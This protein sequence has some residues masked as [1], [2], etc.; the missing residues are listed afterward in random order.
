M[1]FEKEQREK[2]SIIV[3][4]YNVVQYLDDCVRSLI[5]QTYMNIEVILID[6]GSTDL[7]AAIC[8]KWARR[9]KR[10][11]VKH[12]D[13][14]GVSH[15]RNIGIELATGD[16]IG[17][18]DADDWVEKDMYEC[19]LGEMLSR[20]VEVAGGGYTREEC[21]GGIV[22]LRKESARVYSR[23]DILK[24][25][26]SLKP[27]KIIWWELWDKLFRADLVKRNRF[28]ESIATSEDKLFFWQV[29]E[30]VTNFAY[31]PL[32]KYHYRMREGSATHSVINKKIL[33]EI[34][35]NK[36]ILQLAK[37]ESK[38]LRRFA[39]A[40]YVRSIV[41]CTKKMLMY[42][43]DTYKQLIMKN[44]TEIRSNFLKYNYALGFSG[45]SIRALGYLSLPFAICLKLI[46]II[47]S[48]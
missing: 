35:A 33:T 23:E 19:L 37:I 30:K 18:V 47:R 42:K 43:P 1:R 22:T 20:N 13:N 7:S 32:F 34:E 36:R 14:L 39:L 45:Y 9:D 29:M 5:E 6:D 31:V 16:Y 41:S 11:H 28:D 21:F 40:N 44:Q 24:E 25:I 27:K 15:A 12:T 17:F 48:K 38:T 2:I 26:F 4:V 10:I 8:D 3:P 46:F